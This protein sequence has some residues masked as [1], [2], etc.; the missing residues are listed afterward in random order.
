MRNTHS[1]G[2][3]KSVTSEGFYNGLRSPNLQI[4]IS[5]VHPKASI[6]LFNYQ[7]YSQLPNIY[8]PS[9]F[10][11]T[12]SRFDNWLSTKCNFY[13]GKNDSDEYIETDEQEECDEDSPIAKKKRNIKKLPP[14]IVG[15]KAMEDFYGKYKTLNKISSPANGNDPPSM[16][17]YLKKIDKL[18]EIPHTMGLVKW[19]GNSNELTLQ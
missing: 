6:N 12:A 14:I 15:T 17:R 9:R 2:V 1:L 19:A 16:I 7:R 3:S 13:D 4:D 11:L 8:P 18:R 10:Q 5:G